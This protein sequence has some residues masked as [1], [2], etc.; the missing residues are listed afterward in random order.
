MYH[1]FHPSPCSQNIIVHAWLNTP[2][3]NDDTDGGGD[4]DDDNDIIDSHAITTIRF[5]RVLHCRLC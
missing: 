4:G 2:D 3:Y 5:I 1:T